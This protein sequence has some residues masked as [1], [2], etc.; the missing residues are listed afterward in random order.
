MAKHLRQQ[1]AERNSDKGRKDGKRLV[2]LVDF[3]LMTDLGLSATAQPVAAAEGG[4]AATGTHDFS[5]NI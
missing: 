1:D 2:F 4:N 5:K 3:G